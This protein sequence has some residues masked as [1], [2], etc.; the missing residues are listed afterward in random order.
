MKTQLL[1]ACSQL[2]LARSHNTWVVPHVAEHLRP[3]LF[4]KWKELIPSLACCELQPAAREMASLLPW[5]SCVHELLISVLCWAARGHPSLL[6]QE[7]CL[8]SCRV[9]S[10]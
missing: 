9:F 8:A 3:P 5:S 1:F 10:G 4:Q 6:S 2:Y 7:G